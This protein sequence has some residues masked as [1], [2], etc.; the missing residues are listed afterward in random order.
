MARLTCPVAGRSSKDAGEVVMSSGDD[1]RGLYHLVWLEG[2]GERE[3]EFRGRSYKISYLVRG[4]E[5]LGEMR[6]GSLRYTSTIVNSWRGW[7][8]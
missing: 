5:N 6:I 8:L 1:A 3:Y 2:I 4:H 7:K